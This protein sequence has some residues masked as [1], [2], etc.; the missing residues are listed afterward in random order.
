LKSYFDS[1]IVRDL[2]AVNPE[3]AEAFASY[4][5]LKLFFFDYRE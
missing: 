2:R 3:I 5:I 1:I 4:I